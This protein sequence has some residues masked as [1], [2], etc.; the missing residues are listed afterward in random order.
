[1]SERPAKDARIGTLLAGKYQVEARIGRGGMG[2]IYRATHRMLGKPVAI[3]LIN[4][5]VGIS[6]EMA[7]RFERE[8][9]AASNLNHPNIATVHDLGQLEDG[10]L[11]MVMEFI[12]GD[13]LKAVIGRDGPMPPARIVRLLGQ[14]VSAL[15]A[16]HRNGIVHRD[17]KPQNIMVTRDAGGHEVAKLLDFGIAKTMDDAATQLT[18]T[19]L[20]LGTPQYMAPEQANGGQVDGRSDIYAL[21]VILYEMLIGEVPFEATSTPAVLVKHLT[22]QPAPPSKRRPDLHLPAGLEAI[23]LRSLEKD[24][25]KRFQS[26]EDLQAALEAG[27]SAD[28][29]EILPSPVIAVR[30]SPAAPVAPPESANEKMGAELPPRSALQ[31]LTSVGSSGTAPAAV[32]GQA[33]RGLTRGNSALLGVLIL[34]LIGGVGLVA[35]GLGYF[36]SA[37]EV[38]SSSTEVPEDPAAAASETTAGPVPAVQERPVSPVTPAVTEP[39]APAAAAATSRGRRTDPARPAQA[40]TAAAGEP[41]VSTPPE[42]QQQAVAPKPEHPSVR[43]GCDGPADVCMALQS[44][45]DSELARASMPSVMDESGAELLVDALV[46][47]GRPRSE[48]MFGQTFVIESYTISLSGA[49]RRYQERVSMPEPRSFTLDQRVGQARLTEQARLA[50]A[51]VVERLRTYWSSKQ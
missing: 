7:A 32:D 40:A 19:G 46:T 3:K 28:A 4:P 50:A 2:T 16:A 14:I 37:T 9:R 48:T 43:F 12:E 31:N 47:A 33:T 51:A 11:Y 22:E 49:A 44:A 20:S 10:T 30:T 21:G 39:E 36:S 18:A 23:A 6:S 42:A 38:T 5:D 35:Y 41:A 34:A 26:A 1:M 27:G 13:T 17:L 25:A 45:I 8:A 29:T 24:P 15:A